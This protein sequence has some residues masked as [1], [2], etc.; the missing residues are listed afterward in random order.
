MQPRVPQ[1]GELMPVYTL[2]YYSTCKVARYDSRSIG[3]ETRPHWKGE[4]ASLEDFKSQGPAVT[5]RSS[6]EGLLCPC[7]P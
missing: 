7:W 2:C 6:G 4:P 5:P 3:Q 1:Q